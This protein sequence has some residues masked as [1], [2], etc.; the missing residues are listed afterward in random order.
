MAQTRRANAKTEAAGLIRIGG[1]VMLGGC[2]EN[3]M[4]SGGGNATFAT[5]P[6]YFW[7]AVTA[8]RRRL[9]QPALPPIREARKESLGSRQNVAFP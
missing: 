6:I 2:P 5:E 3:S 4:L 1:K 9:A 8:S 7:R